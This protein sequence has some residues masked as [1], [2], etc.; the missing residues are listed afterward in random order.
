MTTD[1]HMPAPYP[2]NCIAPIETTE[3]HAL[4]QLAASS[5]GMGLVRCLAPTGQLLKLTAEVRY[6]RALQLTRR[7]AAAALWACRHALG[8]L[9]GARHIAA[10][11]DAIDK[12]T[13]IEI[14]GAT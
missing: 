9:D 3:L 2:V 6:L 1:P 10:L 13:A 12:L 7:E 4:E 11:D 5:L 14:A 8:P